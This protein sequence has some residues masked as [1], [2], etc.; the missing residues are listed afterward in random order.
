MD[1]VSA[2]LFVL[3]ITILYAVGAKIGLYFKNR[4]IAMI[5][6]QADRE[7]KSVR[8]EHEG[9]RASLS[10][11]LYKQS[12]R[13]EDSFK[14][15]L[16]EKDEQIRTLLAELESLKS[17]KQE[18]GL[19][20]A[21]FKGAA[22]GNPQMLIYKLLEHNQKLNT[23]MVSKWNSIEKQL[24]DDL[25]RTIDQ[26]GKMFTEAEALHRDGLEIISIYEARLPEDMK[27]QIRD[28]L[29]KLTVS[30]AVPQLP[31]G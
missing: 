9:A 28:E 3:V 6:E 15:K 29:L 4:E 2:I 17:W 25:K 7:L 16:D 26:L 13:I 12:K 10:E 19:K 23:A 11:D 30:S 24:S 14:A 8:S 27:K 31:Q 20:L 22:Q 1:T 5:R 18:M 21:E